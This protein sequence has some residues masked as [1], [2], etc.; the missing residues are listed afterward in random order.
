M[1]KLGAAIGSLVVLL[2]QT[3]GFSPHH[4]ADLSWGAVLVLLVIAASQGW[5]WAWVLLMAAGSTF[6]TALVLGNLTDP[7]VLALRGIPTV[8]AL[9]VLGWSLRS[10]VKVPAPQPT[11]N[12][13]PSL[14]R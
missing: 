12:D 13:A 2:W 6:A 9:I 7:A 3:S 8:A 10:V 11:G 1:S 4:K 14:S 5:R